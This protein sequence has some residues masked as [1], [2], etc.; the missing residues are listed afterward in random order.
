MWRRKFCLSYFFPVQFQHAKG[1]QSEWEQRQKE[2]QLNEHLYH[3]AFIILRSFSFDVIVFSL[4]IFLVRFRIYFRTFHFAFPLWILF[5]DTQRKQVKKMKKDQR[6]YCHY[7]IRGYWDDIMISFL[8]L[9]SLSTPSVVS[10]S[11]KDALSFQQRLPLSLFSNDDKEDTRSGAFFITVAARRR[12][13]R[14]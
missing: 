14:P 11:G 5:S 3:Y 9:R 12:R 6:K 1:R 13:H 7:H 2:T 4:S 10:D 8:S